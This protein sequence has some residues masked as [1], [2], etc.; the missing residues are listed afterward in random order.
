MNIFAIYEKYQTPPGLRNHQYRVAAVA[1]VIA[2]RL[3]LSEE[4][5]I[6]LTRYG[7]LHDMGNVVKSNYEQPLCPEDLLEKER[8][9]RVKDGYVKRY[10]TSAHDATIQIIREM[11]AGEDNLEF[12][13]SNRYGFITNEHTGYKW[14][15]AKYADLRVDPFGIVS[16]EKR[17]G[18]IRRRYFENALTLEKTNRE[19]KYACKFEEELKDLGI[20]PET[21]NEKNCEKIIKE[22][23]Y[24]DMSWT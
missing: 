2:T 24:F 10:G 6:Y 4:K 19:E 5:I 22:L 16:L 8:W 11:G 12:F 21:I 23:Y 20:L 1:Q 15:I 9:K 17:I 7:L 13:E 18:D 14:K 3:G